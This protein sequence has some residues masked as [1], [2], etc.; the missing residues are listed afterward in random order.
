MRRLRRESERVAVREG[1]GGPAAAGV[2]NPPRT[3]GTLALRVL[4]ISD[5]CWVDVVRASASLASHL[6]VGPGISCSSRHGMPC[7]STNEG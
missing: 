4:T 6:E 3:R 1:G 5:N 2:H 7:N